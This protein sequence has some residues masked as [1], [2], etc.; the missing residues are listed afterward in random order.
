MLKSRPQLAG[1]V[2]TSG[3]GVV[4]GL[5]VALATHGIAEPAV[6][7]VTPEPIG[8]ARQFVSTRGGEDSVAPQLTDPAESGLVTADEGELPPVQTRA[9]GDIRTTTSY[10]LMQASP[11]FKTTTYEP[12]SVQQTRLEPSTT[13]YQS[14]SQLRELQKQQT[15][16]APT[17]TKLQTY[18]LGKA[19]VGI[20]GGD[21]LRY[22]KPAVIDGTEAVDPN[23]EELSNAVDLYAAHMANMELMQARERRNQ[24][25]REQ[26]QRVYE[27]LQGKVEEI[28]SLR[29]DRQE[30]EAAK[31]E[32]QRDIQ[33]PSALAA[34]NLFEGLYVDRGVDLHQ[35]EIL[36]IDHNIYQDANPETGLFYYSPKRYDLQWDPQNQYAMTVIYG[37]AGQRSGEGEVFMATRLQAG[38]TLGELR[39]AE[40]LLLAYLRRNASN[41]AMRFRELRP[42][43]LASSSDVQLFGGAKNQFTVPPEKISVQG[44]TGLL[45]SMDVS[46]ATD[47]RRLLNVESLLRTDAN[48]HGS[49]TMQA[50]G[51]ESISRTIPLEIAVASRETFGRIPFDPVNGWENSS[52]YPVRL[53]ALHALALAPEDGN[54]IREDQPVVFTW[55]LK[56]TVIPPGSRMS[57]NAVNVP[58]W[59][60]NSARLVW[61]KYGVDGSCD[62]CDDLVFT[63]K[64]IPPPPSTRQILFT[65]GDVFE[66]T[67]A[68]HVRVHVRSPFLDPQRNRVMVAPSVLLDQDGG[69]FPISR[70]FLTDREMNGQ[71]KDEPFYDFRV[72]IVMRDGTVHSSDWAPSRTL[73]YL[74]GSA[75]LKKV[76]GFVPGQE[77]PAS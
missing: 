26:Q 67:G 2:R 53:E 54:G 6:I 51:Q 37:M 38:V 44:I 11:T 72:D 15:T 50:S 39:L 29:R 31:I 64:F 42:L 60:A 70:L 5:L 45:D 19:Q 59:V 46:W 4:A 63:E 74:L 68:Y 66:A 16:T 8:I 24:Q 43:P 71:G 13:E 23:D 62:T 1:P 7:V 40:E 21:F 47:I 57:W 73:D 49:I 52:R 76:L 12:V 30:K 58:P 10:Q 22:P 32:A 28:A 36:E 3:I 56:D 69:E 33:G 18:D 9:I 55:T 77:E 75:S 25:E 14:L 34:I 17:Q 48:I 20:T 35:S 41:S 61:V 27:L 65:T